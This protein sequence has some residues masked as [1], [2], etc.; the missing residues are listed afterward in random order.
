MKP[1]KMS[2]WLLFPVL[3]AS[4]VLFFITLFYADNQYQTPPP[5]GRGGVIELTEADFSRSRPLFLIDGWLL[6]DSRVADMPTYIGEFSNLQR[7][8]LSASPHGTAI[9]RL[10]LRYSGARTE[11][12]VNFPQLFYHH[13]IS[14][15][16]QVLSNGDG[17]A[18]ISFALTAGD[19]LL[20]VETVSEHGYYSGMYHPPSLGGTQQVFSAALTQCAAYGLAFFVPLALALFTFFLWRSAKDEAA[21]WFGLLCCGFS[22]YVSYYFVRLLGLPLQSYWYL[23]QS[24]AFYILCY[25]VMH[26]TAITCGFKSRKS[27]VWI[28]RILMAASAALVLL[29]LLIPI[30]P[31][32]VRLHGALTDAY[33]IFT[34]CGVLL[35]VLRGERLSGWEQRFTLLGCMVFG[36]GLVLNLFF[37]NRFEPILFFWQFEWCGLFLVT[38][39]GAVMAARNKRILAENQAFSDHLEALVEKRTD[40]LTRLLRERKAFFADM[41]HDLKAPIFAAKAFIQA[42]RENN[43]GVDKE[44]ERYIDEVELKQQEMARRV[45]GLSVFNRMDAISQPKTPISVRALLE[46][47]FETHRMAAEVAAVRLSIEPPEP[48]GFLFAQ[49]EK[50]SIL[51]ENLIFNALRAMPDGGALTIGAELDGEGCHLSVADTGRGIPQEEL[52]HIFERFYVGKENQGYG[53][54]MGLAIVKSIAE[55]LDGEVNLSSKPGQG[56]VF[57][58]DLPIMNE[59]RESHN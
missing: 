53:S 29:A 51:F 41:A 2:N 45:Q 37:S 57:Y 21:F 42:I 50:L 9:Y 7:G 4:L 47:I 15:D 8:D 48:D 6:S 16:G 19:H 3:T 55:E 10:S 33:Y 52:A 49:P 25:C 12:A 20:T 1:V 14:L 56:T 31:W 46:Q 5:Y 39:F 35:L 26:L 38:L 59:T 23:I 34:F 40:E 22:L 44:L 58:I 24:V 11:V 13:T 36:T 54:G 43:T 32:A 17:G 27:A 30:L 18:K 28:E